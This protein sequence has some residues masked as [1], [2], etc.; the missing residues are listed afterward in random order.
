ME[1]SLFYI[2]PEVQEAIASHAPILALESTII[3]QGMPYP[4]NLSFAQELL[5]TVR[6]EKVAPAIVAILD[7]KIHIGLSSSKLKQ[8][9]SSAK[10]EKISLHDISYALSFGKTGATTVS[11]TMFLSHQVKINV[12]ATGGIGGVHRNSDKSFDISQDLGVLG[13]IPQVVISAGAKAILDLPKTLEA[14]ETCGVPVLGYR[15]KQFPA[16]YSRSSGIDLKYTVESPADIARWHYQHRGLG[17]KSALLVVNPVPTDKEVPTEEISTYVE[18]AVSEA[19][20]KSISG[21]NLTPFLL[22]RVVELSDGKSLASNISLAI[23]NARLG[24]RVARAIN[25][26]HP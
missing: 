21:N 11:A 3:A 2:H 26:F 4:E 17:L 10:V 14:L 13:K 7:G 16:F 5:Q 8:I 15:V 20:K 6:A 24:A 9:A 22:K 23:N 25:S 12:F 1:K 18:R 19:E